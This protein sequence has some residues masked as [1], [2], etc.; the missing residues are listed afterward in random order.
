MKDTIFVALIGSDPIPR[1]GIVS[2]LRKGGFSHTRRYNSVVELSESRLPANRRLVCLV[3]LRQKFSDLPAIVQKLR[4]EHP[5]ARVVLLAQASDDTVIMQAMEC[6]MQAMECN[7]DGILLDKIGRDVFVK[8][9]E[10]VVL[11]DTLFGGHDQ[12]ITS[13][14]RE[15]FGL[16]KAELFARDVGAEH[17]R[18]D[19]VVSV[20]SAHSLAPHAAI[21]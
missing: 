3:D 17:Q 1:E 11:G 2:I 8:S 15:A 13:I 21:R 9:L 10:L 5:E 20:P 18:H 7:V 14:G 6:N 12:R 19:F 16:R 4:T